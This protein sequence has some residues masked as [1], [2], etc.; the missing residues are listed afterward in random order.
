MYP[1]IFAKETVGQVINRIEKLTPTTQAQWGKMNA[2]QMLAHCNVLYDMTFTDKYPKPGFIAKFFL[3]IF[4]K[5]GVCGPK[6]YPKNARTAPQFL[7]TEERDFDVEKSKM[8]NG[9]RKCQELGGDYFDGK[10]SHSFG[11]LTKEEWNT[12]IYKHLDHHLVQFG[13]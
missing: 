5:G 6:P 11:N 9:L 3:K 10:E 2:P 1:N 7:I 13:V 8:I 4:V 12:M